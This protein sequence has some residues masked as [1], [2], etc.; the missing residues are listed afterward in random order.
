M[1]LR[2]I[3]HPSGRTQGIVEGELSIHTIESDKDELFGLLNA[4]DVVLD[5]TAV[6]EYDGCGLQTLA[7]FLAE[8]KRL[9]HSV[10]LEPANPQLQHSMQLLGMHLPST[11]CTNPEDDH[12]PLQG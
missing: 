1:P 4:S 3:T 2:V 10:E 9:G 5:L 8:M 12:G 7:I 6:T 11:P